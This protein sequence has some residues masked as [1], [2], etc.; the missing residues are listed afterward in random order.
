MFYRE[1]FSDRIVVLGMPLLAGEAGILE[2]VAMRMFI[3]S[4]HSMKLQPSNF[5]ST[6]P[7]RG[8]FVRKR[9]TCVP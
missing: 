4:R 3:H 1:A 2:V 9:A 8:R 7:S 5:S 6:K